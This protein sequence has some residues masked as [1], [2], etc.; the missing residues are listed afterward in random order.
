[1]NRIAEPIQNWN[2]LHPMSSSRKRK[3]HPNS[4]STH[5]YTKDTRSEQ[6]RDAS[7]DAALFIQAYE[8]DIIRGPSATAAALS[9]EIYDYDNLPSSSTQLPPLKIGDSLIR[10]GGAQLG[11][12]QPAFPGDEDDGVEPAR[13]GDNSSAIWVDRYVSLY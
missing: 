1:M 6:T 13:V 4:S 8:A 5:N 2:E 12:S 11:V 3:H 9:L 7:P 10:W